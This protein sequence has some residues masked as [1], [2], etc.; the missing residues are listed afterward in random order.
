MKVYPVFLHNLGARRCVV[1]GGG[2]EAERKVSGLLEAEASVTVIAATATPQLAEWAAEG[3]IDWLQRTYEDG[4]LAGAFLVICATEDPGLNACVAAAAAAA[5]ALVN[6]VDDVAHSNF[7]AGSVVRRGPLV[8]GISTSGTAPALAVRLREQLEETCGS[9]FEEF[10]EMMAILR[11]QM[12]ARFPAF[13]QRRSRYYALV[14]SDILTLL[15]RNA[16]EEADCRLR[17]I[18]ADREQGTTRP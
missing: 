9:E 17:A 8:I 18:L 16:P 7:V 13:D 14:D 3:T 6:A 2:T 15:R 12:G 5:G 1:V 10:L 4:D 11:P